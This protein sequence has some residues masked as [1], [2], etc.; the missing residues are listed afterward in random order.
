MLAS[1][2]IGN[3][4]Q[5]TQRILEENKEGTAWGLLHL[6]PHVHCLPAAI[7]IPTRLPQHSDERRH[8]HEAVVV[9]LQRQNAPLPQQESDGTASG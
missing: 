4:R 8:V 6:I 2:M 5:V 7:G 9:R 1:E 3:V